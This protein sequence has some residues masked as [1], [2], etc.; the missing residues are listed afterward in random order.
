MNVFRVLLHPRG[1]APRI[2]GFE[3]YSSHLVARLQRDAETSADPEL[4]ALLDEVAK[5]P[6]VGSAEDAAPSSATSAL[7]LRLRV[8]DGAGDGELA[9]ITTIATFGTPFDVTVSE[10]VIESLFPA[11][12]FTSQH[13]RAR[14]LTS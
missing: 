6:G 4:F 10:L 12:E 5:Y 3:A 2:V 8:R 13:L 11:D 7:L 9:F 14:A 1:L